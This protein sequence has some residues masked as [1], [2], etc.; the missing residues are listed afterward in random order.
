MTAARSDLVTIH[1]YFK[2]HPGKLEEFKAGL[3]EFI[4]R[5]SREP[6]CLFYDF[7]IADDVVFCRE[8]Y[9]GAE[10]LL[11]HAANVG[12]VLAAALKIS[13]L[14][15]VEI[16]GPAAELDKLRTACAGLNP[17]WFAYIDGVVR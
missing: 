4:A 9:V 10:G 14:I 16:H 6:A 2:V 3:R 15:R 8:G 11:A 12:D 5:T 17:V 1:P 13:D 7:T